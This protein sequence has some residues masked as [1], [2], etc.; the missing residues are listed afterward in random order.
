MWILAFEHNLKK[1]PYIVV[2]NT[3]TISH[4]PFGKLPQML[5]LWT[6]LLA[7]RAEESCFLTFDCECDSL[8]FDC[9]CAS[10]HKATWYGGCRHH[11]QEE[12]LIPLPLCSLDEHCEVNSILGGHCKRGHSTET[13]FLFFTRCS[14]DA[15]PPPPSP[16]PPSS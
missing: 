4:M 8:F 12:E 14:E 13:S 7:V 6:S 9:H 11:E 1:I 2:N 15:A 10:D 5:L 16:S 3:H